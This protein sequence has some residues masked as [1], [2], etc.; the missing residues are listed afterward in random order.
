MPEAV[1]PETGCLQPAGGV[2]STRLEV[3]VNRHMHTQFCSCVC[4]YTKRGEISKKEAAQKTIRKDKQNTKRAHQ[5]TRDREQK[6][7][8]Q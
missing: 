6:A 2:L 5:H 7:T 3:Y 4:M 8:A 1:R